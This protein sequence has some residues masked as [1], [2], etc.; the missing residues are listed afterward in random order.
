MKNDEFNVHFYKNTK[1]KKGDILE[2]CGN[3]GISRP[4]KVIRI[5]DGLKWWQQVLNYL[6]AVGYRNDKIKCR[7]KIIKD[8][9]V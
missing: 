6:F 3:D 4:I 8:D 9:D 2:F 5:D 1:I 7:M